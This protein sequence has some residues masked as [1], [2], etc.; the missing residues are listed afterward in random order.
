MT[1]S[2]PN[3]ITVSLEELI[4]LRAQGYAKDNVGDSRIDYRPTRLVFNMGVTDKAAADRAINDLEAKGLLTEHLARRGRGRN[5]YAAELMVK[6]ADKSVGYEK[7]VSRFLM[8]IDLMDHPEYAKVDSVYHAQVEA[9]IKYSQKSILGPLGGD[10]AL[11]FWHEG[12]MHEDKKEF[13][14][15]VERFVADRLERTDLIEQ[16]EKDQIDK[17]VEIHTVVNRLLAE[18]EQLKKL[19]AD[20]DRELEHE[21]RRYAELQS[22]LAAAQADLDAVL[23]SRKAIETAV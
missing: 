16:G 15:Q 20:D 6:M 3:G 23:K 2:L 14:A 10:A 8:L 19:L 7:A 11:R 9:V 12:R 17:L 4:G 18:T 21:R 13:R 1:A 5:E 22:R